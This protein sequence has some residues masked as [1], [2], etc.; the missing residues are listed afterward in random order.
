MNRNLILVVSI[1][2]ALGSSAA[3]ALKSKRPV[4]VSKTRSGDPGDD[5]SGF[6]LAS[7][8]GRFVAIYTEASN[9]VPDSA[10]DAEDALLL[11]RKRR[12]LTRIN[13]ESIDG[14]GAIATHASQK[15]RYF[16]IASDIADLAPGTDVNDLYDAYVWDRV[17]GEFVL[18]S[19]TMSGEAGGGTRAHV[20]DDGRI[21]VFQSASTAFDAGDLNGVTDLF[22]R[23]ME[24]GVTT[25]LKARGGDETN[26]T[27]FLWGITS[28]GGSAVCVSGATNLVFNDDNGVS[29]VFVHDIA[30]VDASVMSW[31]A[32]GRSNGGVSSAAITPDGRYVAFDSSATNLVEGDSNGA[33]DVFVRDRSSG[34][35]ERVSVGP[36]GEESP[37]GSTLPQISANGRYVMFVS[38]AE[39]WGEA[40]PDGVSQVWIRDRKKGETRLLSKGAGGIADRSCGLSSC[41]KSGKLVFFATAATNL[42]PGLPADVNQVYEVTIR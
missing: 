31:P 21:C 10:A 28:D 5:Y 40:T 29:D 30:G 41:S 22:V 14:R 15:G 9:L 33:F 37:A 18:V 34:L 13:P 26:G 27:T 38:S 3:F 36:G 17:T 20:S 32:A 12:T 19:V 23:D 16:G 42:V 24:A 39:N 4:L 25:R 7:G 6:A 8:S 35:L 11:D 1:G 2:A